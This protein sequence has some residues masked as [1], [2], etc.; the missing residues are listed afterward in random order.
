MATLFKTGE[1]RTANIS[2]C[3]KYRYTLTIVWDDTLPLAGFIGLNPST[4]D[5]FKD[6]NTIRKCKTFAKSWGCGGIIMLNLFAYR[7]TD[8]EAMKK[9]DDPDGEWNIDDLADVLLACNGPWV[10]CWGT[11]GSHM[12]RGAK[13]AKWFAEGQ[14]LI[15][16]GQLKC[17]GLNKDGSPKHPLYLKS[18]TELIPMEVSA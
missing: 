7:S 17:F 15:P 8:P 2:P 13:I 1:Q 6:D 5:E 14:F 3:Q 10:A 16:P 9:V 4:A 12:E 18:T 11:H